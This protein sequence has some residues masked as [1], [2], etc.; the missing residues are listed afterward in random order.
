MIYFSLQFGQFSLC[1]RFYI[2]LESLAKCLQYHLLTLAGVA[3]LGT[4]LIPPLVFRKILIRCDNSSLSFIDKQV[5][6]TFHPLKYVLYLSVFSA[7]ITQQHTFLLRH[8][9]T[10]VVT[11]MV[12]A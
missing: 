3:A 7:V 2:N 6:V 9:F 12:W 10:T 11:E 5:K 4:P 8:L 1:W